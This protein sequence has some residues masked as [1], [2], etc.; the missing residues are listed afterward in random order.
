MNYQAIEAAR[1]K[2][3]ALEAQFEIEEDM[4][5]SAQLIEEMEKLEDLISEMK[6]IKIENWS[7]YL[8][9]NNID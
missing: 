9:S 5:K 4:D 6:V 8:A 7:Q 2:L 3:N 1:T